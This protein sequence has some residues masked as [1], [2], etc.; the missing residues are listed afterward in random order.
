MDLCR[1][2]DA[3]GKFVCVVAVCFCT[4][5]PL[6]EGIA[7]LLVPQLRSPVFEQPL[8]LLEVDGGSAVRCFEYIAAGWQNA[9]ISLIVRVVI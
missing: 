4:L 1:L 8:Y 3:R 6:E 7:R 5:H 9:D 2:C